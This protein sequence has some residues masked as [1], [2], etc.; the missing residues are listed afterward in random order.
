MVSVCVLE[1][2]RECG[3]VCENNIVIKHLM[4]S[5]R[6]VVVSWNALKRIP[7]RVGRQKSVPR[8]THNLSSPINIVVAAVIVVVF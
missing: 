8:A 7:V 6:F 1:R 2:E 4:W 5:D 3:C